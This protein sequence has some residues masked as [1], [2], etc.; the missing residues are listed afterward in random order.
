MAI[1]KI[2]NQ[3]R[4]VTVFFNLKPHRVS[5]ALN[6]SPRKGISNLSLKND[7]E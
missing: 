1:W 7:K 5:A 6:P 3:S 2:V 4:L